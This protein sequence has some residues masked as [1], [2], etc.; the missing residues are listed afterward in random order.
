MTA[1]MRVVAADDTR[2]QEFDAL[3]TR[4]YGHRV[5]DITLLRPYCDTRVALGFDRPRGE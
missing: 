5:P 4:S 3:A 2:W 1:Q